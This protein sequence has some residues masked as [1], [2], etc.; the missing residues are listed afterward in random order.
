M[1]AEGNYRRKWFNRFM[2][3]P[4]PSCILNLGSN[5]LASGVCHEQY[6][7]K[8]HYEMHKFGIAMDKCTAKRWLQ[9]IMHYKT[10]TTTIMHCT[11]VARFT[12][13]IVKKP[14]PNLSPRELQLGVRARTVSTTARTTR[15]AKFAHVPS[16]SFTPCLFRGIKPKMKQYRK[17]AYKIS[18]NS[19][20]WDNFERVLPFQN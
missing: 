12:N 9:T 16:L 7:V 6:K 18:E 20:K 11:A 5:D 13:V 14:T 10:L 19:S 15:F 8:F 17:A 2:I 3:T 1:S 4:Q